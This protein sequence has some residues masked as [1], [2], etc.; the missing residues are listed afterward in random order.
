MI[1]MRKC[2]AVWI[3]PAAVHELEARGGTLL[4]GFISAESDLGAGLREHIG[5]PIQFVPARRHGMERA[6]FPEFESLSAGRRRQEKSRSPRGH[7]DRRAER[8]ATIQSI[9]VSHGSLSQPE[10]TE[11]TDRHDR[12]PARVV[13][14]VRDRN[15][16]PE[17]R[18]GQLLPTSRRCRMA[19]AKSLRDRKRLGGTSRP[20]P[21]ESACA[22]PAAHGL[23]QK[24]MLDSGMALELAGVRT[25]THDRTGWLATK[26]DE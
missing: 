5:S 11:E 13:Q 9:A 8:S 19:S 10:S 22:D 18:Q 12:W 20:S 7:F 2:P 24:A 21:I 4:I 26:A 25:R 23:N 6:G 1:T 16:Q 17:R 15:A 3:R 14:G